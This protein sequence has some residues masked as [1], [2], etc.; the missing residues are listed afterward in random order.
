MGS[1]FRR[2]LNV[3]KRGDSTTIYSGFLRGHQPSLLDYC[4][5]P[6]AYAGKS[7]RQARPR[8]YSIS[9]PAMG[10]ITVVFGLVHSLFKY[11]MSIIIALAVTR[12]VPTNRSSGNVACLDGPPV[13]RAWR[14]RT[15]ARPGTAVVVGSVVFAALRLSVFCTLACFVPYYIRFIPY[16]IRYKTR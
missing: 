14:R 7:R 6:Y 8:E 10:D 13:C 16:I 9:V 3:Q 12:Y 1:D 5:A 4:E 11:S 2:E 15:P